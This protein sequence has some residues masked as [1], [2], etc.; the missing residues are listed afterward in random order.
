MILTVVPEP[1]FI[2]ATILI[3]NQSEQEQM[4]SYDG[5]SNEEPEEG[6]NASILGLM[7]LQNMTF[8]SRGF[9]YL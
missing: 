4:E 9:T 7:L 5:W 6:M 8:M 2:L 1:V 3:K